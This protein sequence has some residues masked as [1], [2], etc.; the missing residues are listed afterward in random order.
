LH[1]PRAFSSSGRKDQLP[2][3]LLSGGKDTV[4]TLCISITS[5]SRP[6][7]HFS[8]LLRRRL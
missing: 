3:A 5:A 4:I 8:L 1:D 7:S 2:H 6:L